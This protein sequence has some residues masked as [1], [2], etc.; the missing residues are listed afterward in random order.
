[1]ESRRVG[2]LTPTRVTHPHLHLHLHLLHLFLCPTQLTGTDS[3]INFGN[4]AT[5]SA[6][7]GDPSSMK[8]SFVYMTPTTINQMVPGD[9]LN[10][11]AHLRGVPLSCSE[12]FFSSP[13]VGNPKFMPPRFYC[14]YNGTGGL[15]VAGPFYAERWPDIAEDGSTMGMH[16]LYNCPVSYQVSL[17][18][19]PIPHR[20]TTATATAATAAVT[21]AAAAPATA[22]A[23]VSAA[24]PPPPVHPIKRAP[25]ECLDPGGRNCHCAVPRGP[26]VGF[27][28]TAVDAELR[29]LP[30]QGTRISLVVVSLL[31]HAGDSEGDDFLVLMLAPP[32]PSWPPPPRPR[33]NRRLMRL[34]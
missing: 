6:E 32:P 22:A 1:V 9:E 11:T 30:R 17:P 13:C 29:R 12:A 20:A 3:R 10:L 33:A 21:A 19:P 7:C 15:N 31:P 2:A 28:F 23:T 34:F 16:V 5:L 18:L 27:P 8:A 25:T 14:N 26:P 4:R 24:S